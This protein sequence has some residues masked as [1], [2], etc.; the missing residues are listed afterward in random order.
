MSVLALDLGTRAGYAV[1]R[2]D[3]RVE[4]DTIN[5][6]PRGGE[7]PSIR[8]VIFRRA[9]LDIKTRNPDITEIVYED[10]KRHA[11]TT[12]AHVYGG[13]K[14]HLEYFCHHHGI[15]PVGVGVGVWK[16]A[17][18]GNGSA[19]KEDVI[20]QCRELGFKPANDNEADAIGILHHF[21]KRCPDLTPTRKTS[22]MK[23][24]SAVPF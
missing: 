13:F 4:H 23:P 1:L 8:W 18:T 11:G 12:A 5:C 10:V 2:G 16:K 15:E 6:Q 20:A 3:N 24:M 7:L 19:K 22:A 9:L 21:T 17:F 14:A